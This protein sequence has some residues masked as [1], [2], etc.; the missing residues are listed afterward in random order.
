MRAPHCRM[1]VDV[2]VGPVRSA[3]SACPQRRTAAAAPHHNGVKRATRHRHNRHHC[4]HRHQPPA[5]VPCITATGAL[6]SWGVR[7]PRAGV[8]M[9]AI[10][11]HTYTHTHSTAPRAACSRLATAQVACGLGAFNG[12][13]RPP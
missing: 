8:K 1:C 9:L 10:N 13:R 2:W 7:Q 4:H 6:R 11:T 12:R 5:A 3:F